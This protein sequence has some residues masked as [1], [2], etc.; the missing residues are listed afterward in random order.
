MLYMLHAI[1]LYCQLISTRKWHFLPVI[2][3]VKFIFV[4][5]PM[6][7][8]IFFFFLLDLFGM[9]LFGANNEWMDGWMNE[10]SFDRQ[11]HPKEFQKEM[12]R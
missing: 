10:W 8:I 4:F 12:E 11:G 7:W 1:G 3:N 9:A 6:T 2:H 5:F